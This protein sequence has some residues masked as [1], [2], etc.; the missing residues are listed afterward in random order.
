MYIYIKAY[1]NDETY[2]HR[3]ANSVGKHLDSE[4]QMRDRGLQL[5]EDKVT[6]PARHVLPVDGLYQRQKD[7]QD[8]QQGSRTGV[9]TQDQ[10][11]PAPPEG[12]RC[13]IG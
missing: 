12:N 5:W 11:V 9:Q 13:S 4:E 6:P 10:E 7:D 1:Y 3:L 2:R 8:D